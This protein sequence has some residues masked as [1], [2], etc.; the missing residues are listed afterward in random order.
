MK[1]GIEQ[2]PVNAV[3][4]VDRAILKPNDYNPN[5]V[6]P[7]ELDLLV[8]SIVEDGWTQPIVV[9]PDYTIVDGFHRYT[10]SGR[11]EL[12]EM[13]GGLVPVVMV[14][15]DKTHRMMS[16][17]R[18][19]RARGEHGV[20]H[21]ANIVRTMYEEGVPEAEIQKRL[22][23]EDEE[24]ERLLDRSGMTIRASADGFGKAWVPAAK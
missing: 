1:K 8:T 7:P 10:V 5:H 24:V 3:Q 23:M 14:D 16:T 9:L 2:Q 21:M 19:N 20:L 6:A 4:W 12:M 22:G 17:I 11:P 18:H 15:F 13:T